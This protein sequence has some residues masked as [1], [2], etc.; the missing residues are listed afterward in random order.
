MNLRGGAL[1]WGPEDWTDETV[2]EADPV[3][4]VPVVAFPPRQPLTRMTRI[5]RRAGPAF[6]T[7]NPPV[8]VNPGEYKRVS[9]GD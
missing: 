1:Y 3:D 5:T 8:K 6:R 4:V 7:F 9:K 2:L